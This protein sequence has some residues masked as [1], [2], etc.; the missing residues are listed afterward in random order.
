MSANR[1]SVGD[2]LRVTCTDT[3]GNPVTTTVTVMR[4]DRLFCGCDRI[5]TVRPGIRALTAV[6]Y[7]MELLPVGC[8]HSEPEDFDAARAAAALAT[9]PNEGAVA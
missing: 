1:A 9:A 3:D 8:Y 7:V 6:E 2:R 5:R 4:V